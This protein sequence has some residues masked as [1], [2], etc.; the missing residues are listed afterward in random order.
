MTCVDDSIGVCACGWLVG[1][2]WVRVEED[3]MAEHILS[4]DIFLMTESL[5]PLCLRSY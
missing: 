1:C 2:A 4:W 5:Y 3:G